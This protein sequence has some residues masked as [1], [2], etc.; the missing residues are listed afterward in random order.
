MIRLRFHAPEGVDDYS[1]LLEAVFVGCELHVDRT[2]LVGA[3][4]LSSWIAGAEEAPYDSV[5]AVVDYLE[6]HGATAVEWWED[7]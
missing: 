5:Q 1:S 6:Y 2:N 4:A 7:E 3:G